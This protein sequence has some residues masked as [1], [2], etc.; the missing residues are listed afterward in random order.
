MSVE[1]R[2]AP[3]WVVSET[4]LEAAAALLAEHLVQVGAGARLAVA[5][6]SAAAALAP[7]RARLDPQL[8]HSLRVTWVDERRVPFASVESNR[9]SAHRAGWLGPAVH[10]GLELPL[11]LDDG[12]WE[13]VDWELRGAM[14]GWR[15][16][17][18]HATFI[19]HFGSKT[20]ETTEAS[21]DQRANFV[22]NRTR[23][24]KKWRGSESPWERLAQEN[25][26]KRGQDP[27]KYKREDGTYRKWVVAACRVKN[28]EQ[29]MHRTL[30][31]VSEFADEAQKLH[32][33]D[34][35][36]ERIH[37][38]SLLTNPDLRPANSQPATRT[39]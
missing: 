14:M 24:R 22:T 4:P 6:G 36:V 19:H 29:W 8:W 34:H 11:W 10:E 12:T 15:Y 26:R 30:T 20:I 7:L 37:E 5:G 33:V 16:L 39:G 21:K 31:R 13:E 25:Y 9:G 27:E 2:S 1:P 38:T 28:G 35:V 18:D 32:W 23:F 3:R 17:V